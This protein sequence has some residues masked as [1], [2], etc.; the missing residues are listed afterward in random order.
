[1]L[2]PRCIILYAY[3]IEE[4][5]LNIAGHVIQCL[6]PA[7]FSFLFKK[8]LRFFFSV[9]KYFKL[10]SHLMKLILQKKRKFHVLC[11]LTSKKHMSQIVK[12]LYIVNK[13]YFFIH[14]K[15]GQ[16]ALYLV[17]FFICTSSKSEW[18]VN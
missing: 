14:C 5:L 13:V 12:V 6:Q 2:T 7:F 9:L 17:N 16:T 1:M 3:C 10:N 18:S 8:N 11:V 4:I 15:N